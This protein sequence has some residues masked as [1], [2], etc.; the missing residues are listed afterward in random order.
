MIEQPTG[1]VQVWCLACMVLYIYIGTDVCV[2]VKLLL[3]CLIGAILE[4][5]M[6]WKQMFYD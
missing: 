4:Q 3:L 1:H 6:E 2:Y 5:L